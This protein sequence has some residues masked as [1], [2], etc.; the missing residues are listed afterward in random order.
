[1]LGSHELNLCLLPQWLHR[2]MQQ[3]ILI[4]FNQRGIHCFQQITKYQIGIDE[5]RSNTR[6]I[7]RSIE[8]F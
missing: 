3:L 1:M 7:A 5:R 4:T 6:V 2:K 8:I